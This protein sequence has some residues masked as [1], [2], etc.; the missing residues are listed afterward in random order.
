[1]QTLVRKPEVLNRLGISRSTLTRW[2]RCG[3]FP[4]PVQI[5]PRAV[6]WY[7]HDLESFLASRQRKSPEGSRERA[8]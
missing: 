2:I 6:G 5:G 3:V 8:I 1:M 4:P 7:L